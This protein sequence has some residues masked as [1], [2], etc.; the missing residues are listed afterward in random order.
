MSVVVDRNVVVD[1]GIV[2]YDLDNL[3]PHVYR[4]IHMSEKCL[5]IPGHILKIS[6]KIFKK[7]QKK[8]GS[9][10][11]TAKSGRVT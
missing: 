2:F 9:F 6:K 3:I 10:L 7:K 11:I 1:L 8:Q 5:R 4:S